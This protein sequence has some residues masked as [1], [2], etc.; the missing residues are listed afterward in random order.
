M[1]TMRHLLAALLLLAVACADVHVDRVCA[2][3]PGFPVPA[4]RGGGAPVALGPFDLTFDFGSTLPDLKKSGVHDVHAWARSVALSSTRSLAFVQRLTVQVVPPAGSSLPA[5]TLTDFTG[6]ASDATA[7]SFPADGTDLYP[8]LEAGRLSLTLRGEA[9]PSR[10]PPTAGTADATLCAEVEG[11][12]D[13]L[14]AAG[15]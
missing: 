4:S 1:T 12:V 5:V 3:T 9:D 8:Y 7:L 15:L 13:Y 11:S 14:K 2:T 6:T 10:L